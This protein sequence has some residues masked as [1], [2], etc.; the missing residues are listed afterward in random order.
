MASGLV[1][2]IVL[3]S[4]T[5]KL[6]WAVNSSSACNGVSRDDWLCPVCNAACIW[7]Y[8]RACEFCTMA[9]VYAVKVLL[10]T[11]KVSQVSVCKDTSLTCFSG[12]L[13]PG[14]P[15]GVFWS[16]RSWLLIPRTF[17]DCSFAAFGQPLPSASTP[18]DHH[19]RHWVFGHHRLRYLYSFGLAVFLHFLVQMARLNIPQHFGGQ[20]GIRFSVLL[21][22]KRTRRVV[23]SLHHIG[24]KYFVVLVQELPCGLALPQLSG[25]LV[26]DHL[27]WPLPASLRFGG[28]RH[29]LQTG[30]P[31]GGSKQG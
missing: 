20:R 12:S 26:Y 7:S 6:K 1:S 13:S 8:C 3:S 10:V 11:Y 17:R 14:I 4:R 28:I 19:M 18:E 27:A 29:I 23:G 15:S 2:V 25:A 30:R 24:L 31:L 21:I 16:D 9:I 22:K 5:A